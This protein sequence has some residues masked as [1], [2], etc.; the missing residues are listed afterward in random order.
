LHSVSARIINTSLQVYFGADPNEQ[1][2]SASTGNT[3]YFLIIPEVLRGSVNLLGFSAA[4][5]LDQT[6]ASKAGLLQPEMACGRALQARMV[7]T[8]DGHPRLDL[9]LNQGSVSPRFRRPAQGFAL[10]IVA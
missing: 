6:N 8:G 1:N 7:F 5:P 4:N 9:S 10:T 3:S 2:G